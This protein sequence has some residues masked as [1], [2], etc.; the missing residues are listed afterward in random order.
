MF[1]CTVLTTVICFSTRIQFNDLY[2]IG[3]KHDEHKLHL[4][5]R[6]C[7]LCVAGGGNWR[8]RKVHTCYVP[9]FECKYA[10]GKFSYDN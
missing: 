7:P 9:Q 2:F 5:G 3:L 10:V 6:Y 8:D 4:C 1:L